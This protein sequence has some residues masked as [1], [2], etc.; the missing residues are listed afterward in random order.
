MSHNPS[1][2][3]VVPILNEVD[4]I[5]EAMDSLKAQDYKPLEVVVYD[6]GSTDGTLQILR[7]YPFRLIVEK[8]LGQM[9]AINR[10]WSESSADFVMWMAGDDHLLPGGIRLLAEGLHANPQAGFVHAGADTIDFE[11]KLITHATPG[12]VIFEDLLFSFPIIPQATMIRRSALEWSGMMDENLRLAADWDLFLRLMQYYPCK[13][14]R[15]TVA[16]RR[17]HAG[18]EDAKYPE[19]AGESIM[20]FMDRFFLRPDLTDAQKQLHA[21]GFAGSRFAAALQYAAIGQRGKACQLFVQAAK[22]DSSIIF[23]AKTSRHLLAYMFLPF[24]L[25][26]LRKMKWKYV[27]SLA[28]F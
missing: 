2:C 27:R 13:Y 14:L 4:Y 9:A 7:E 21:R 10:G 19:A 25:K 28:W 8:G 3:V 15:H 17:I 11:G 20:Y 12:D 16:T 5:R 26:T 18:S 23:K 22:A 24:D 1:V 6:A